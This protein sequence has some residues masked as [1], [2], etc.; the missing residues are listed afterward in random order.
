MTERDKVK[1]NVNKMN[2]KLED[3]YNDKNAKIKITRK[4]FE[5]KED[6]DVPKPCDG[7][8]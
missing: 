6:E 1:P 3:I 8:E 4:R 2:C 7:Y 5:K